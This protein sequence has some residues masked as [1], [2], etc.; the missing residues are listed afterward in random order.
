MSDRRRIVFAA[1]LA[2]SAAALTGCNAMDSRLAAYRSNPTPRIDTLWQTSDEI[3]NALTIMSDTNFR[4]LN[5]DLG[6]A[7]HADRPSR[8]SPAPIPY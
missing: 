2:A 6:R 7:F 3:D 8:L 5:E 4:M 1:A